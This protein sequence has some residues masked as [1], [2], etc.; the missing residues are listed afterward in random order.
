MLE[1]GRHCEKKI[2][3]GGRR[4]MNVGVGEK[5]AVQ[6]R[7]VRANAIDRKWLEQRFEGGEGG[8]GVS[9]VGIRT[10]TFKAEWAS[11]SRKWVWSVWRI[12]SWSV[13]VEQRE[14]RLTEDEIKEEKRVRSYSTCGP[15][16]GLWL[17]L[18]VRWE[19]WRVVG[20]EGMWPD[21]GVHT[22][23]LAASGRTDQRQGREK[24]GG[25]AERPLMRLF[26]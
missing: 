23:P 14:V 7:V 19:P 9:H 1:S 16:G 12:L 18:W 6:N 22:C 13:W 11:S 25:E 17:L 2:R 26:P 10:R 21:S 8:E 20:R 4:S 15:S 24:A 5:E 3:I